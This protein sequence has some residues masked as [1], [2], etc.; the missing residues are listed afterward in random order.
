MRYIIIDTMN[1]FFR[2]KHTAQRGMDTW[3]K[4]GMGLHMTLT[5]AA[6]EFREHKGDHVVFA[7][8][9][10]NNWRKKFYAPYKLKRSEDREAKHQ[11]ATEEQQEE[12]A[13][14]FEAYDDLVEFLDKRTNCTVLQTDRCEGDDL[15]ARWIQTHPDD[16]HVIVSSD[17]DFIQLVAPNVSQYN[18]VKKHLYTANGVYDDK[19][20][21]VVDKK[22]PGEVLPAPEPDWELFFKCI[23]GDTGDNVF[24][25]FPG[26][27]LKGT[28]N[29]VG[30]REAYEDRES[31]GYNWNNF[32]LQRWV[33]HKGAE[34]KVMDDFNRNMTLI[35]LSKQP[36]DIKDAMD[37]TIANAY[38]K[39]Q[40]KMVGAHLLK[41]CGKYE[42]NNVA[43]YVDRYADFL[44][45]KLPELE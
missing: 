15:M 26:A 43:K 11:A 25:A 4:V 39:P 41:F 33:D 44:N 20:L 2:C 18:G 10:R 32:M 31:Q 13:L 45:A 35:D 21:P 3:Q 16:E 14:F 9:G 27:R 36:Q 38:S 23:R 24:S 37:L 28:K 30:I 1:M 7:L 8:E 19:G 29:K 22:N 12:D 34:H 42:L 40:A 5:S 6:K 17:T